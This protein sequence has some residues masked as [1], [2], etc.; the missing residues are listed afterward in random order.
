MPSEALTAMPAVDGDRNGWGFPSSGRIQFDHVPP[1]S[2]KSNDR[3][4]P[5]GDQSSTP[6][7]A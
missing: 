7:L 5:S 4:F 1:L 6:A 2:I 3:Y